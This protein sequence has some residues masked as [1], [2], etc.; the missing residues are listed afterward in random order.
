MDAIRTKLEQDLLRL[1]EDELELDDEREFSF[2]L[3]AIILINSKVE[4]VRERM[5]FE[6]ST[7][8]APVNAANSHHIPQSS[9]R[10]KGPAFLPSEHDDLPPGMAFMV[11]LLLS[12][13]PI[14][15]TVFE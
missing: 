7:T 6:H 11:S 9:R 13:A 12:F 15:I 1:Q 8:R 2:I 5:D 10:R 14:R 4:G 3:F